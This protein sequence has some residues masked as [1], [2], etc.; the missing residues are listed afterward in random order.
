MMV[1]KLLSTAY[2]ECYLGQ[3]TNTDQL[4]T[5]VS[6]Y[7]PNAKAPTLFTVKYNILSVLD[8]STQNS[9]DEGQFFE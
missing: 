9:D 4:K 3:N 5:N 7:V 6:T 1:K 8:K 2:L